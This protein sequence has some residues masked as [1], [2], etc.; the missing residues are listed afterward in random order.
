MRYERSQEKSF[1]PKVNRRCARNAATAARFAGKSFR[2]LSR[3]AQMLSMFTCES[4]PVEQSARRMLVYVARG[5][6]AEKNLAS[7]GL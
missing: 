6:W 7:H 3:A 2:R 5:A 4:N 1:I